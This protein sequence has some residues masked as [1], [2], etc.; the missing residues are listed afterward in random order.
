M[1]APTLSAATVQQVLDGILENFPTCNGSMDC[2]RWKYKVGFYY[3]ETT[4]GVHLFCRHIEGV[5]AFGLMYT[6]M[7]GKMPEA[8]PCPTTDDQDAWDD[9]LCNSDAITFGAFVQLGLY[10]EIL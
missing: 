8:P 2:I 4:E 10:G 7:N 3:F 5:K 9:W 1:K 6:L